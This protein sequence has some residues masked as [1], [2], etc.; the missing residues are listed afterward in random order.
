MKTKIQ[1][2]PSTGVTPTEQIKTPFWHFW[3]CDRCSIPK[4]ETRT[5]LLN[6]AFEEIHQFGFQSASLSRILKR[7]GVTK[8]ALYHYFPSKTDLGYAVLD[9][10][11][12]E[13]MLD[14]WIHP[15]QQGHP[16]DVIIQIIEESGELM[17]LEDIRLGCPLANLSQEMSPV[18]EGFRERVEAQY[19]EWRSALGAA[20][21]R[22][23][24][25]GEVT[26]DIDAE[27]TAVMLV[28]SLEGCLAT[29]KNAQSRELLMQ[30]GM[31][32]IQILNT[33][34]QKEGEQL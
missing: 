8:G 20:L 24:K 17:T 16:I 23:Q 3:K 14:F 2:L 6:A 4:E 29:A 1:K 10:M 9:E 32:L 7:T 28:A 25:A 22:G 15:L 26:N 13:Q 21:K 31:S 11:I 33:F 19:T 5:Q 12:R 30:C 27:A 18:D 34:R